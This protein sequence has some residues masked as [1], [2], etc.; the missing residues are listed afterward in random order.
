MQEIVSREQ[1]ESNLMQLSINGVPPDRI[2]KMRAEFERQFK[3]E[4]ELKKDEP[5][6]LSL[7]RFGFHIGKKSRT[8]VIN[9]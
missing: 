7:E 8:K 1:F 6:K 3:T 5:S 9:R 4:E 2:E